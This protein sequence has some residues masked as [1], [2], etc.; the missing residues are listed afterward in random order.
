M[1]LDHAERGGTLRR[2]VGIGQSRIDEHCHLSG[3]GTD[4]DPPEK[5]DLRDF[6]EAARRN[7]SARLA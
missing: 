7:T 1:L 4:W 2:V 5:M 3:P 6:R